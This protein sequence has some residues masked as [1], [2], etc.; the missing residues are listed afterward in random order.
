[1]STNGNGDKKSQEWISLH[2]G[3]NKHTSVPAY[4]LRIFLATPP[5]ATL[6]IVSLAEDLP[7]PFS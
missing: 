3:L 1:L 4:S 7:P 2:P 6:P 5:A